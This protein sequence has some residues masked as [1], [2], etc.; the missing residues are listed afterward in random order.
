MAAAAAN[1]H[2]PR[3]QDV[4]AVD[5]NRILTLEP[6]V[7]RRE[8]NITPP[9]AMGMPGDHMVGADFDPLDHV[10]RNRFRA[11]LTIANNHWLRKTH[12]NLL[13]TLVR[14]LR[15]GQRTNFSLTGWT[16][17]A[18]CHL[19]CNGDRD[20]VHANLYG[21]Y[22]SG[23]V[24]DFEFSAAPADAEN[25]PNLE[26]MPAQRVRHGHVIGKFCI[27]KTVIDIPLWKVR[28]Y[29]MEEGQGAPREFPT[30]D[31]YVETLQGNWGGSDITLYQC[32]D[33]CFIVR[34]AFAPPPVI[35]NVRILRTGGMTQF[36][37]HSHTIPFL[38]DAAFPRMETEIF[39]PS[40]EI[41]CVYAAFLWSI[42]SKFPDEEDDAKSCIRSFRHNL[43]CD[44]IRQRLRVK[45]IDADDPNY[46]SSSIMY[47]QEACKLSK[48][49]V[50]GLT[51][52]ELMKFQSHC[53]S[54]MN[55]LVRL[56]YLGHDRRVDAAKYRGRIAMRNEAFMEK[57]I[58]QHNDNGGG[59]GGESIRCIDMFQVMFDGK[60]MSY[61]DQLKCVPL[62]EE[63][64]AAMI[65]DQGAT[66]PVHKSGCMHAVAL[67]H[68]I[69]YFTSFR[70]GRMSLHE[71]NRFIDAFEA[72]TTSTFAR[73]QQYIKED[74]FTFEDSVSEEKIHD[75]VQYQKTLYSSYRSK[76]TLT[77]D[78]DENSTAAKL[79][80][81]N[82]KSH[83]IY[84][85][86]SPPI[87]FAYDIETVPNT[88]D[89]QSIVDPRF[90][91]EAGFNE[92]DLIPGA[93][94]YNP[95]TGEK[96]CHLTYG[97]AYAPENSLIPFSC[98]WVPVN[99]SDRGEFRKRK[100]SNFYTP[101]YY[102][103]W[104][105]EEEMRMNENIPPF[106]ADQKLTDIILDV[107][108]TSNGGGLLGAC[109]D[110][111]LIQMAKSVI[112]HHPGNV[113]SPSYTAFLYAHNGCGFDAFIIL[114]Y[115]RFK[116]R[117]I[118]KTSR[119]ILSADIFVPMMVGG[120]G[121]PDGGDSPKKKVKVILRLR[122]TKVHVAGSLKALCQGFNVP[123]S[124]QKLDFPIY[125]VNANNCYSDL[126]QSELKKY[127]ENDILC[128][129][130]ILRMMN[131]LIGD[132]NWKPAFFTTKKP[133]LTQF[134]TGV[135]MIK[136]AIYNHF[137]C[138]LKIPPSLLPKAVDGVVL[139]NFIKRALIGG[140]VNCYAKS[141]ASY[142][143]KDVMETVEN[144]THDSKQK[145]AL[146]H[147]QM[148]QA[149]SYMKCMDVTSLYPTVQAYCPMP[150]GELY[151]LSKS[152][153]EA[154]IRAI[155][156]DE[157]TRLFTLCPLHLQDTH[158]PCA[159]IIVS[160]IQPPSY[161][162][163]SSDYFRN[164]CPRKKLR[165]EDGL[166]YSLEK[167]VFS[168]KEI[169]LTP[170]IDCYTN[171]DLYWMQQQGFTFDV[172]CGFGWETSFHYKSFL[173]PA[174]QE[175]IEAKRAGN[176]L[177]SDFKKRGYNITYGI[178]T[179]HDIDESWEVV[180]IPKEFR[181]DDNLQMLS[182]DKIHQLLITKRKRKPAGPDDL[183]DE[184]ILLKNGKQLMV[185]IKKIDGSAETFSN[186][187]TIHI[188]AFVTSWGRH[189]M[190]LVMFSFSPSHMTY[191]DTDSITL[192]AQA[193]H[194]ISLIN[195]SL[196]N[197]SFDAPLGS[198]KNEHDE[199]NG[200]NPVIF[201]SLIGA[202]KVKMHI[203]LNAEG[204]IKV[205]NTY[206]G[207]NPYAHSPEFVIKMHPDFV[208]RQTATALWN[209]CF[210]GVPDPIQV[211]KWKRK[212][213][214]GVDISQITQSP[215]SR[216]Y[217]DFALGTYISHEPHG[218]LEFYIPK[219]EFREDFEKMKPSSFLPFQKLT[220]EDETKETYFDFHPQRKDYSSFFSLHWGFDPEVLHDAIQKSP[221]FYPNALHTEEVINPDLTR[222]S[223]MLLY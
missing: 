162:K 170:K 86:S 27:Q 132:S 191:T 147:S 161:E 11:A 29:T 139:R 222:L 95:E 127:G 116:F 38:Y 167:S 129:A 122:D 8:M 85:K 154:A 220:R 70:S 134:L 72:V 141:Y 140:R 43:I 159:M 131:D 153:A 120:G 62:T 189:L 193:C 157:C 200:T 215:D 58:R 201:M 94:I 65:E 198:Y 69:D 37:T 41:T 172:Q 21:L 83:M 195:P 2:L 73:I 87:I 113:D 186:L 209:I 4:P 78:N 32:Y 68:P 218:V 177:I 54:K 202:K 91:R 26:A 160:N 204:D 104:A 126:I 213:D 74:V 39:I 90:R 135:S 119:G 206:K 179:Q 148:I 105:L 57:C 178:A 165:N 196:I 175:R 31:D 199:D 46:R 106:P 216:T 143:A 24:R 100:E 59:G 190:N 184:F 6:H 102:E 42:T 89:C 207:L 125:L 20:L 92:D 211:S 144:V 217:F 223:T 108:I 44:A 111:M 7:I 48:R 112:T 114:Q 77:F 118:L 55:V 99:L 52:V 124:W 34:R 121:G 49:E 214:S 10:M 93:E 109:V 19:L 176:K 203:T 14:H 71:E 96:I 9:E 123:K 149:N 183:L 164:M 88:L 3:I 221:L 56:F 1:R 205:Y 208:E 51:N 168:E 210:K 47:I 76:T 110:D 171:V 115:T 50:C 136:Q 197:Q 103:P 163:S 98:Q 81:P 25:V 101:V 151:F 17:G 137:S 80:K 128:L 40:G 192:S 61:K 97:T 13:S 173:V 142:F 133:P 187:S 16:V 53:L 107:P 18:I 84:E 28:W 117:N 5:L 156:C 169:L 75:L 219:L 82:R 181:G 30:F 166:Y 66:L 12:Y 158:R 23:V 67:A 155:Q 194:Q 150:T 182:Q 174:F 60:L 64:E 130:Y 138:T 63:A 152:D 180:D 146:I 35:Q 22:F 185:H 212:M 15:G 145:R 188:G 36:L 79:S 45:S 33:N